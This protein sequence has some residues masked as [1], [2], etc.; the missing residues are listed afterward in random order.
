MHFLVGSESSLGDA[1]REK[2]EEGV[3]DSKAA[4]TEAII[5]IHKVASH[6]ADNSSSSSDL[7]KHRRVITRATLWDPPTSVDDHVS[8]F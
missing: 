8:G 3:V 6:D 7:R 4:D 5:Q 2:M 1:A